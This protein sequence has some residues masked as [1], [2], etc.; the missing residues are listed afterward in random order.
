MS[1]RE[2]LGFNCLLPVGLPDGLWPPPPEMVVVRPWLLVGVPDPVGVAEPEVRVRL[3]LA[4]E[5]E[6]GV[7]L[8]DVVGELLAVMVWI[9]VTVVV[10]VRVWL[11]VA[12][13]VVVGV[14]LTVVVMN[15]DVGTM[16]V[17]VVETG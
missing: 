17:C 1:D 8:V 15:T 14:L 11:S 10:V 4:V 13:V 2:P 3:M 5:E 7:L 12:V 6:D 16:R 9:K